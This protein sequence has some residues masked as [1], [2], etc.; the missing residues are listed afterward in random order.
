MKRG[1]VLPGS[2]LAEEESIAAA[3]GRLSA[4]DIAT[5]A[6]VAA[7]WRYR[8]ARNDAADPVTSLLGGVDAKGTATTIG[9]TGGRLVITPPLV[10]PAGRG[11]SLL[12]HAHGQSADVHQAS[13]V[14]TLLGLASFY[15]DPQGTMADATTFARLPGNATTLALLAALT[16][17]TNE[18]SLSITGILGVTIEWTVD[19][20]RLG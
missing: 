10:V 8:L 9:L 7:W 15:N 13:P 1:V 18:M 12:V 17:G 5:L 6:Q 11:H 19:L 4:E 16:P 2:T 14:Y 20:Y 3:A